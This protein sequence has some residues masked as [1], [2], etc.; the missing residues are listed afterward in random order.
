M[1]KHTQRTR[2]DKSCSLWASMAVCVCVPQFNWSAFIDISF[3][4]PVAAESSASSVFT[5]Q[6]KNNVNP[7]NAL[8]LPPLF[9]TSF[10]K[11][12][13]AFIHMQAII[14]VDLLLYSRLVCFSICVWVCV[15]LKL[16]YSLEIKKHRCSIRPIGMDSLLFVGGAYPH[17]MGP[18]ARL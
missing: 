7:I 9:S 1:H 4:N 16:T 6:T 15:C 8:F 11:C 2:G 5:I 17:L 10:V 3:G 18:N 12:M 13:H 14:L